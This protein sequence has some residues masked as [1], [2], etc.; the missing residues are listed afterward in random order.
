MPQANQGLA[1]NSWWDTV[2]SYLRLSPLQH[3]ILQKVAQTCLVNPG[4]LL[5]VFYEKYWEYSPHWFLLTCCFLELLAYPCHDFLEDVL[6]TCKAVFSG[7]SCTILAFSR[8]K[9]VPVKKKKKSKLFCI[10]S[11]WSC[12]LVFRVAFGTA[13]FCSDVHDSNQWMLSQH[14]ASPPESPHVLHS[15]WGSLRAPYWMWERCQLHC[16]SCDPTSDFNPS[17]GDSETIP[18]DEKKYWINH[19]KRSSKDV[20]FP[21]SQSFQT[22]CRDARRP[23]LL[24]IF[25]CEAKP[26]KS[27]HGC[28][29]QDQPP[30]AN[31]IFWAWN[32]WRWRWVNGEWEW[33]VSSK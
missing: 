8:V 28:S 29:R 33:N 24:D 9:K 6:R 10:S 4:W 18:G 20:A 22:L 11:T 19:W 2:K 12:A 32:S 31:T 1:H 16:C 17:P 13:D 23:Q 5:P 25:S 3:P 27:A 15:A 30:P 26:Q 21:K 7:V 14:V